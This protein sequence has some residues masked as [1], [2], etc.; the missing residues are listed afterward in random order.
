MGNAKGS[1]SGFGE[2]IAVEIDNASM[3]FLVCTF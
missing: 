1:E 2:S 3:L